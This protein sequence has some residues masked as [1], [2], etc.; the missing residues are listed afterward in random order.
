MWAF[1]S[2]RAI[3]EEI[4]SNTDS[5]RQLVSLAIRC[6]GYRSSV[7]CS[8]NS[9]S[10]VM[11]CSHENAMTWLCNEFR[12][13]DLWSL[14]CSF[15]LLME[16][17]RTATWVTI[18]GRGLEFIGTCLP[19]LYSHLRQYCLQW[20][21]ILHFVDKMET[22]TAQ[23]SSFSCSGMPYTSSTL[24]WRHPS[25]QAAPSDRS[26]YFYQQC[27][28]QFRNKRILLVLLLLL[29]IQV[30]TFKN[31]VLSAAIGIRILTCFRR[32]FQVSLE[33]CHLLFEH[34]NHFVQ[35]LVRLHLWLV[36]C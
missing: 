9:N 33:F 7:H 36:H 26:L 8:A 30:P 35:V 31:S 3:L 28:D 27:I 18:K 19:I 34:F 11:S 4:A 15:A 13:S 32:L 22:T 6:L 20:D 12:E 17:A 25:Q 24:L 5:W 23:L 14:K 1:C 10:N 16:A 29:H 2:P 21:R